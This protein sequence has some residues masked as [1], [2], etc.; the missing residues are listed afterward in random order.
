GR[1][2]RRS[3]G[4]GAVGAGHGGGAPGGPRRGT[5][6]RGRGCEATI[7]GTGRRGAVADLRGV[8]YGVGRGP[9]DEP[10]GLAPVTRAGRGGPRAVLRDVAGA[11]GGTTH[12]RRR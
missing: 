12:R 5:A 11:R 8:A 2:V 9:A 6:P 7:G 10:R 1:R 3:G 4:W